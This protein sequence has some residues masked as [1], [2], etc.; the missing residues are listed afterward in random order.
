MKKACSGDTIAFALDLGYS[1][2][3]LQKPRP[4]G[5]TRMQDRV[6]TVHDSYGRSH[7]HMQKHWSESKL[8]IL[9]TAAEAFG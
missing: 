4:R 2:K 6:L 9:E 7:V 3:V 1:M 8:E 5:E